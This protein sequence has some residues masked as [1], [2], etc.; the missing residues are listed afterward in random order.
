[1]FH[2]SIIGGTKVKGKYKP[3]RKNTY[4]TLIGDHELDL[5]QAEL[6][7]DSPIKIT[8]CTLVGGA[9]VIV[10]PGTAV[11]VGGITLI[12]R[13]KTNVEPGTEPTQSH[14]RIRFNCLAGNLSVTSK[15][16][17]H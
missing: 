1:M 13:K 6:P 16:K 5:H 7:V 12:G 10:R 9:K 14:L 3:E 8:I 4:A 11:D 17:K 15:G 2:F